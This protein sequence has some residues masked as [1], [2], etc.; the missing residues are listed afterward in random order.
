VK[1]QANEIQKRTK[2]LENCRKQL[3]Q[4]KRKNLQKAGLH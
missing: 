1:D 3:E 4:E 2:E